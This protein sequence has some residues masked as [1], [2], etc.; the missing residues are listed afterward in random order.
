MYFHKL[1]LLFLAAL[2]SSGAFALSSDREQPIQIEADKATLD[3]IKMIVLYKGNVIIVQGSIRINADSVTLNY[4]QKQEIEKV[5]AMGKP[6]FFRQRLDGGDEIKAKAQEMEYD[7]F[8]NT[9]YLKRD[10]ELRKGKGGT[11]TYSSRAPRITYDTQR[12]IIKAD[13][14]KNKKGR[15]KMT[16][17]PQPR[18]NR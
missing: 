15:I 17:K 9:L 11:N 12:G 4:T 16:F 3:N 18:T 14:G 1:I 10:A 5:V 13:G 2:L 6:A 8:S 7:A